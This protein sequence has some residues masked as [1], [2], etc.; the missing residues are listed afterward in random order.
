M[1]FQ[2]LTNPHDRCPGPLAVSRRPVTKLGPIV[3]LQLAVRGILI[4][5]ASD[6]LSGYPASHNFMHLIE[7]TSCDDR[8]I[9]GQW[10]ELEGIK[11]NRDCVGS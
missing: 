10:D 11:D 2:W 5:P 7:V 3:L 9:I 6:K 8:R 1:D 4:R